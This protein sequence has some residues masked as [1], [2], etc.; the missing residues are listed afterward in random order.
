VAPTQW[1]SSVG[2]H[3]RRF[4]AAPSGARS[5]NVRVTIT[6]DRTGRILS[7]EV[8]QGSGQEALD[9]Q[10]LRNVRSASPIPP[11]PPEQGLRLTVPIQF[12]IR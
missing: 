9:Q 1:T 6:F 8:A 4:V 7:A 10:A 3:I 2:S 11:P 5:G 12:N